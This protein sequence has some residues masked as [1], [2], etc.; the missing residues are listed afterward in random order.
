MSVRDDPVLF[1]QQGKGTTGSAIG[2]GNA[3]ATTRV[4]KLDG[5]EHA[6]ADDTTTLDASDTR[7]G[8]LPKL[9]GDDVDALRGDGTYSP[10]PDLGVDG[11][12]L[13]AQLAETPQDHSSMG[14]TET[15]DATSKTWHRGTLNANCAITV[16]GFAVDAGQVVLCKLT[17]NGTGGY[18]VVWDTDVVFPAGVDDQPAQDP[19]A[20]TW[21]LLWSDEGDSTVYGMKVGGASSGTDLSA[22]DFLVGTASGDLS[23]EI[24]V[25]T[26]PGGELG[27]TW[28]SP[29]VDTTHSG[30]SHAATQAAAEATAAAALAAHVASS[31][32]TGGEHVH[33]AGETHLS[34]GSTTTYTLDEAFE[35][36]S[37]EAWNTT[38]LAYL[39]VTETQPDQA[40]VSAAG[41]SG[42]KITFSY[43]ASLA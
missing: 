18:A 39:T 26:T 17:Q 8:L 34:D 3:I 30:S 33:V 25:G 16:T 1:L 5:P 15:I 35:P 31:A 41:S 21:F 19:G 13:P 27:G 6:A 24:V 32:S 2:G 11:F 40:T 42:D 22:I 28:P 36:G 9:S 12:V 7:H 43:A 37:V 23:A 10:T 4:H 29:T 38:T 14:S 20:V